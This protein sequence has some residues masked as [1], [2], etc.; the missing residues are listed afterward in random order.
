MNARSVNII[1]LAVCLGLL[2]TLGFTIYLLWV[3]PRRAPV[4]E[5]RVISNTVTQ[6][7]IAVRKVG[8][9]DLLALS[10]RETYDLPVTI[11]RCSNNFGP[12]Q[13]PEKVIPL[14]V[15]NLLEGRKVPL[16]GDGLNV[17]DWLHVHDHC[18]ALL[19]VLEDGGAAAVYNIGGDNEQSNL[20]LTRMILKTLGFGD[21]MIEP[22]AD[23]PG[24][25]R[26]YAI[27]A[28]RIR[29]DLGWV[30][31]RSRWPQALVDTIEWYRRHESWWRPLKTLSFDVSA[32]RQRLRA[33]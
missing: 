16:Y 30:P 8:T 12:Y 11:T 15:T 19:R 5:I 4:G 23:R 1:L 20:Q 13:H 6:R 14:F 7:Q 21:E 26:R 25:D 3:N 28:T 33:A 17:R 18:E 31:T 22:V 29:N 2:G 32:P 9:A 27:D 24:H 10:Y